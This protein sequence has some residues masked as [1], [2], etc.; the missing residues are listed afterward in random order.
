MEQIV[1]D[2]LVISAKGKKR[3]RKEI[4]CH[5]PHEAKAIPLA[6]HQLYEAVLHAEAE[7]EDEAAYSDSLAVCG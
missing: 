6:T 4:Y 1:K 2:V 3:M 7:A 5:S